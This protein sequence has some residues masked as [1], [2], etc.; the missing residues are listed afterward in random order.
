VT[1]AGDDAQLV[2]GATAVDNQLLVGLLGDVIADGELAVAAVAALDADR[3]VPKGAVDVDVVEGW[4][5]LR[6]DVRRHYQRLAAEHAVGRLDG[7][8]G[9]TD[10]IAITS[11]PIPSDVAYRIQRAQSMLDVASRLSSDGHEQV[12]GLMYPT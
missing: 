5:T 8:L 9:V 1:R 6:G 10:K 11:D 12:A 7:V 2:G 3:F 4:I